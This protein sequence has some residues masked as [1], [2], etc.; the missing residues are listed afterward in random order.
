MAIEINDQNFPNMIRI[1]Q[2]PSG[3][4]P[5]EIREGWVG[6]QLPASEPYFEDKAFGL[7]TG[8]SAPARRVYAVPAKLALL[9]LIAQGKEDAALWWHDNLSLLSLAEGTLVFG[10]DEAE[11]SEVLP[12]G[13]Y[14]KL[15]LEK[16]PRLAPGYMF[17][18]GSAPKPTDPGDGTVPF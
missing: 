12:D 8:K 17:G 2:V 16:F 4:A 7:T 10:E 3:D 1:T 15:S 5:L 18:E 6:V 13:L 11:L 14:A 9:Y